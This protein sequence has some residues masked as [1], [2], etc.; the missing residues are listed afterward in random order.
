MNAQF[1]ALVVEVEGDF[2]WTGSGL[3]GSG[4]D[5]ASNAINTTVDWTSTVTGR[6]GVAFDR[7]LVYGKG[8][9]AFA[10]DKSGFTDTFGNGANTTSMRTGWTA[11]AGLEY[12]LTRNWSARVEYDYLGFGSQTL[13][14]STPTTPSYS[15][16]ATLGVQEVKAGLNFRFGP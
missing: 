2:T 4:T 13:N 9:V 10:D 1:N 8:G 12:G 11:G 3:R 14:F 7:V 6:A 16:S 5:S 15:S